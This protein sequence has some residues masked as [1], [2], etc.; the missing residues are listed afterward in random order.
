MCAVNLN[1][2][3]NPQLTIVGPLCNTRR[4]ILW[5]RA[6]IQKQ[7]I[8]VHWLSI[9][10]VC[11]SAYNSQCRQK[12]NHNKKQHSFHINSIRF[13]GWLFNANKNAIQACAYLFYLCAFNNPRRINR[14]YL[15]VWMEGEAH[16]D[17]NHK[18]LKCSF[19]R[20]RVRAHTRNCR[21]PINIP[22]L[23]H[24]AL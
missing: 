15:F 18:S 6:C 1:S 10:W 16:R 14:D 9:M 5:C 8:S 2:C 12:A 24:G 23:H 13:N 19:L 7:N 4:A 21:T 22:R 3:N 17:I 11:V 20:V